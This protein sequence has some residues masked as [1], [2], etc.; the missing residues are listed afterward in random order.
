MPKPLD[1]PVLVWH[2]GQDEVV[3]V[4]AAEFLAKQLGVELQFFERETH[5]L[6]RRQW[7]DILKRVVAAHTCK[8]E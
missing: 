7:G 5:S 8:T 1:V 2:G 4:G 3:Q 6:V